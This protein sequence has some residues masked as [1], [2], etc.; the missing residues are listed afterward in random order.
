[1]EQE[2]A[3]KKL[4]DKRYSGHNRKQNQRT[5]TEQIGVAIGVLNEGENGIWRDEN[6]IRPTA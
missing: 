5:I 6:I 4:K 1:M 3:V 2:K